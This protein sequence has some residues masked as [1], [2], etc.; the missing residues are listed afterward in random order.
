[1]EARAALVEMCYNVSGA[2]C[3]PA[4]LSCSN[5]KAPNVRMCVAQHLDLIM[6]LAGSG[7]G[8][9]PSPTANWPLLERLFKAAVAFLSEGE[10]PGG[11]GQRD[12]DGLKSQGERDRELRSQCCGF[13]AAT[14]HKPL[15]SK[16]FISINNFS[17]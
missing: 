3:V 4:L 14:Q 5:H 7:V 16:F 2:R 17:L 1:M 9:W 13:S 11:L 15:A 10:A 6:E 8:C 12:K